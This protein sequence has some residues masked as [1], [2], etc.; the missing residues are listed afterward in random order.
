M[1]VAMKDLEIRGAG[2]L[3]GGEQSGHIADVG[4]DLYIRL[5]G[6]A[7]ANY[8]GDQETEMP[9]CRVELPIEA[10]IPHEYVPE[11][12]LRL[13]AYQRLAAAASDAD[14][15]A[16]AEELDDRYGSRPKPVDHLL[17]VARLR[18]LARS[19]GVAE[20]VQAGKQ[21]RLSPVQ[22][23]E[24]RTMRL[25]RLYPGAQVKPT[26]RQITLPLPTSG[27]FGAAPLRDEALMAWTR[28]LLTDIV[29]GSPT[30]ANATG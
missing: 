1:A 20:I 8:R 13:E 27:G 10:H 7:I 16:V 30:P 15:A 5:V 26:T 4:F 25:T 2:N 9:E 18:V 28:E 6:E 17:D 12:R 24:S 11:E 23:P 19:A 21:I 22:L 29:L 14:I 3:L